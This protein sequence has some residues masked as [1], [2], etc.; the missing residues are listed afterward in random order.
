MKKIILLAILSVSVT[1][2][3]EDQVPKFSH[4]L[5]SI[6]S[7]LYSEIQ[8]LENSQIDSKDDIEKQNMKVMK[9]LNTKSTKVFERKEYITYNQAEE[10]LHQLRNDPVAK[11][12][13]SSTYDPELKYGFCF[14]RATSVWLNALGAGMDKDSIKKIFL[15]GPMKASGLDWQFHVATAVRS[16]DIFS[17]RWLVIDS[18]FDRPVTIQEFYSFFKRFNSDGSLRMIVSDPQRLGPSTTEKFGP[19]N[20]K[21]IENDYLYNRYFQDLL[22]NFSNKAN[23]KRTNMCKF[24]F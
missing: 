13:E 18:T 12:S 19:G 5:P 7:N 10:L 3:A 20:Y 24:L 21:N 8:N 23:F 1:S 16:K 14:G 4:W 22:R 11:Y 17:E 9:Q 2:F 6:Q 15:L